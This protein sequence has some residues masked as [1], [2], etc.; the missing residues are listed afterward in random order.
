M[1]CAAHALHGLILQV[2]HYA[3]IDHKVR[4][5]SLRIRMNILELDPDTYYSMGVSLDNES[6]RDKLTPST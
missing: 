2:E 3:R 5:S 1:L 4:Y 6:L